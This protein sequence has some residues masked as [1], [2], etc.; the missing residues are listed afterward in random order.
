MTSPLHQ[1]RELLKPPAPTS[2]TVVSVAEDMA[3]VATAHGTVFVKAGAPLTR[4]Q[5]VVLRDGAAWP[6]AAPSLIIAV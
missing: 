5:A 3:A 2:G 1:L 4:G 6:V